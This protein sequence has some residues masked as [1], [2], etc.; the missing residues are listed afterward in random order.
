MD[1]A[2]LWELFRLTGEPLAYLI[3]RAAEEVPPS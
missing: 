1:A 3:Y 2:P